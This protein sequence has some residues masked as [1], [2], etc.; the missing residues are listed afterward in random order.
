[1]QRLS[2]NKL[3]IWT[4]TTEGRGPSQ[5]IDTTRLDRNNTLIKLFRYNELAENTVFKELDE[6]KQERLESEHQIT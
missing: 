3:F 2:Q 1:M 5:S 4:A 6:P